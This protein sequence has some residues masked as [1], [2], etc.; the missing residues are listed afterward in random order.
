MGADDG[1]HVTVEDIGGIVQPLLLDGREQVAIVEEVVGGPRTTWLRGGSVG[2]QRIEA[3]R[4]V[5]R[6]AP[7]S[8]IVS[9][10]R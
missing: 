3:H 2:G 8:R 9:P 6:M 7:S 1:S 4:G 10:L 5:I